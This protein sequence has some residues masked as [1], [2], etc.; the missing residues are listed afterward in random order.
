MYVWH[1]PTKTL[2]IG[3][4][5]HGSLLNVLEKK[6]SKKI[7]ASNVIYGT[8]IYGTFGSNFMDV[9]QHPKLK[10]EQP[11]RLCAALKS[12]KLKNVPVYKQGPVKLGRL[13]ELAGKR[14]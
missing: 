14:G 9:R 3:R 12:L 6:L 7:Q 10:V 11:P 2:A 1:L 13:H 8:L 4:E 5:D